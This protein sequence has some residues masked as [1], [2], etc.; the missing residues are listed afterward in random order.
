MEGRE[1][2]PSS[3]EAERQRLSPARIKG[4]RAC[5]KKVMPKNWAA[6]VLRA[7]KVSPHLVQTDEVIVSQKGEASEVR[8]VPLFAVFPLC[9]QRS[10][11]PRIKV[12]P[13][14]T[15]HQG[16]TIR[17]PPGASS[18]CKIIVVNF[19]RSLL[20]DYFFFWSFFVFHSLICAAESRSWKGLRE[21]PLLRAP[22]EHPEL[23]LCH[24]NHHTEATV[25]SLWLH[26]PPWDWK[27]ANCS[28]KWERKRT[29]R[30]FVFYRRPF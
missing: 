13:L 20:W 29:Q 24:W 9:L 7:H 25:L 26:V 15:L 22:T 14:H 6:P 21:L 17:A 4:C 27:Q 11:H 12:T 8:A 30:L 19:Y 2:V 16:V 10:Q 23:L 1:Q 28:S 3:R 5:K 18:H